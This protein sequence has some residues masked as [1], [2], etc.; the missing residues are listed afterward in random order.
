M[1]AAHRE[2]A[3]GAMLGR[4]DVKVRVG[5]RTV[6]LEV[7]ECVVLGAVCPSKG[8]SRVVRTRL[9][10]PSAAMIQ[11]AATRSRMRAAQDRACALMVHFCSA[12]NNG[13]SGSV[14]KPGTA[15]GDNMAAKRC[16]DLAGTPSQGVDYGHA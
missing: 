1:L 14:S 12:L 7:A 9:C 10:A 6:D 2:Q 16:T 11:G 4:E 15:P 5:Q 8:R 13:R 3:H